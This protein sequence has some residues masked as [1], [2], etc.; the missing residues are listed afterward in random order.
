ML[1][2]MNDNIIV[3][4]YYVTR[5]P[6]SW[7]P[8][9]ISNGVA[10]MPDDNRTATEERDERDRDDDTDDDRRPRPRPRPVIP[11]RPFGD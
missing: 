3:L 6:T 4:R 11:P 2:A 7:R 5:P 1:F 9:L 10:N 8:F